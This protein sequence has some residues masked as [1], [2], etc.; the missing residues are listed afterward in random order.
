MKK[1]QTVQLSDTTKVAI[2]KG[3]SSKKEIDVYRT[4]KKA[5]YKGPGFYLLRN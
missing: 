4:N 2:K 5:G 3:S 1:E